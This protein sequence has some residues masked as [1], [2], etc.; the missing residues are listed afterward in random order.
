MLAFSLRLIDLVEH[1][2][3]KLGAVLG[4]VGV[5]DVLAQVVDA[6]A[7]APLVDDFGGVNHIRQLGAGDEALGETHPQRRLLGEVAQPFAF[8]KRDEERPQHG[9]SCET[10]RSGAASWSAA[11]TG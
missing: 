8:G 1:T 11:A 4:L 6:D 7:G 3:I 10:G 2:V 5:G 9:A